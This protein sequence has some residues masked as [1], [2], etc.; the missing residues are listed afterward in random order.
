V[1][2]VTQHFL[3]YL[4]YASDEILARNVLNPFEGLVSI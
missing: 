2:L 3:C 4:T 1:E